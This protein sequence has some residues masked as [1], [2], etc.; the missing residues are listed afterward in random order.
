MR[1]RYMYTFITVASNPSQ[2]DIG[3]KQTKPKEMS[4]TVQINP[5]ISKESIWFQQLILA[6]LLVQ[7]CQPDPGLQEWED[8]E[9]ASF[10]HTCVL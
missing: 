10:A 3:H 1:K 9:R 5:H 7:Q 2:D 8:I 4:N 6:H